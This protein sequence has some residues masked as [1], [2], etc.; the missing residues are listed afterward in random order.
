MTSNFE[1]GAK[2]GWRPCDAVDDHEVRRP[3]AQN[4]ATLRPRWRVRRFTPSFMDRDSAEQRLCR[5]CPGRGDASEGTDF[6]RL[7]KELR[8]NSGMSQ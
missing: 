4:S 2:A 5:A 1:S 6:G 7:I 8:L 3:W